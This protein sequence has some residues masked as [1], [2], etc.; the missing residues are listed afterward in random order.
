LSSGYLN[1]NSEE[2]IQ[3]GLERKCFVMQFQYKAQDQGRVTQNWKIAQ[4]VKPGDW[5][6]MYLAGRRIYAVGKVI[7][8]ISVSNQYD[9]IGRTVSSHSHKFLTGIVL[10]KDAEAFYENLSNPPPNDDEPWGQRF[11]V[12]KWLFFTGT[13]SPKILNGIENHRV[14][15][16]IRLAVFG[17]DKV[18]FD[19]A[20]QLLNGQQEN[21]KERPVVSISDN[22]H[23]L[24]KF[25]PNLI[26]QGPPG[27]SKTYEA[28]RMAIELTEG[29]ENQWAIVQFHPS[30]NYEDFVRGIQVS[31][32]PIAHMPEYNSVNRIIASMAIEA[33]EENDKSL[34]EKKKFVLIID[35]INRA[36]LASVLGELIYALE[37]RNF[38][39]QTPYVVDGSN[40]IT[41]P[42]NLYIIGT[43]NTADRS[44]GHIDYAVRRRF[45][46]IPM[47]PD[48]TKC[49]LH[50]GK[51]LFMEVARLFSKE[52]RTL[53]PE[54]HADDVQPGHTYFMTDKEN[55]EEACEEL[56]MKFTYQVH[57]LLRE[58]YKDGI[59]M[60]DPKMFD[61]RLAVKNSVSPES[62]KKLVAMYLK[63][64]IKQVVAVPPSSDGPQQTA[65]D[66][67]NT[68][69]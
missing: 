57:P 38:P 47:L 9:E 66:A 58:Y 37:Y 61:G 21:D 43:M 28:K 24:V 27:T 16:T 46:F 44:I 7:S 26:L 13:E 62:I 17:V 45:A 59:L 5:L 50:G 6:V 69:I 41:I 40:S 33:S 51:D 48:I 15:G 12:E 22:T 31:T 29:S 14:E 65:D 32:N 67:S 35:E 34:K 55:H 64:G 42:D 19:M 52:G 8:P 49:Y 68:E 2:N 30:Y 20:M 36:H 23:S 18:L 56:A 60:G 25:F 4:K 11:D 63:V 53:S 54:F 1:F 39:V 10:Y 3:F